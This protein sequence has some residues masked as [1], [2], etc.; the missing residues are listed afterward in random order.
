MR[1]IFQATSGILQN[2]LPSL[3]LSAA[4]VMLL[5]A[6]SQAPPAHA[7]SRSYTSLQGTVVD[8]SGAVIPGAT[9]EIRNPVS[10]FERTTTTD[11]S[12]TFTISNIPFNPYHMTVTQP[13]F[14]PYVQD[15]ELRSPVPVNL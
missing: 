15:V 12:G 1:K 11:N 10:R 13:G 2:K 3:S 4:T 8:P 9:V 6:I 5:F 7:Q 14:A